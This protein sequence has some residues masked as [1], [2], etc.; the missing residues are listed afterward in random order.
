MDVL[1]NDTIKMLFS[2]LKMVS[3]CFWVLRHASEPLCLK[4]A[5]ALSQD[6]EGSSFWRRFPFSS[7]FADTLIGLTFLRPTF[8]LVVIPSQDGVGECGSDKRWSKCGGG[9]FWMPG[10]PVDFTGVLSFPTFI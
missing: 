2:E 6:G 10:I 8:A 3:C 9:R 4:E 7:V 1:I 5:A